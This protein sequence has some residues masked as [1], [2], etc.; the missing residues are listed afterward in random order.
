MAA[1][2]VA[3]AFERIPEITGLELTRHGQKW[4]GPYYLNKDRHAYRRE[5]LKVCLWKNGIWLFEEGGDCMSL[6]TW[7]QQYGGARDYWDA[8]KIIEGESVG[9]KWDS[10]VRKKQQTGL[11]VSPD[12]LM[13]AKAYP[14]EKCSLFRWMCTMFEENKVRE[15]WDMYNVTTDSHGNCCYWYVDQSGKILFDKRILYKEDGHR[16]K[17]FFPARQFRVGD[18]Y[19]HRCYFGANTVP[20][21]GKVFVCE[22]EKSALLVKLMY[23]KTAIATGGKGNLREV[24]S[25]MVL[26]PDMDARE[27]SEK[28][29]VWPWWEKWGLPFEQIPDHADIG[30]MIEWKM[31][32]RK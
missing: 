25:R 10:Q 5:K 3:R 17:N 19:T 30:D 24:D 26:L 18:G 15:V 13:G 16:D 11:Y 29:E 12:V 4:Q 32:K 9:F 27:W 8:I 20:D 31:K 1:Y 23:G 21:S 22:S 7:L 28:G 6:E 14:L 2:R